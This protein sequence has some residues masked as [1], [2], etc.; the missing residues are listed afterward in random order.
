ME[1]WKEYTRNWRR[2]L[3]L[4]ELEEVEILKGHLQNFKPNTN[5]EDVIEW[6][7]GSKY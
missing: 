2:R 3:F 1:D 4:S 7:D 6:I 5:Q